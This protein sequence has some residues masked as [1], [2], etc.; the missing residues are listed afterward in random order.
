MTASPAP[1]EDRRPLRATPP[2]A[3]RIGTWLVVVLG[4]L[5]ATGPFA[6]DLYLPALPA[7]ARDFG[8]STGYIAHSVS[9]FFVGL[10]VGQFI[11]GPIS[12]RMGRR[13][14]LLFGLVLF[15]LA[16]FGLVLAPGANSLI[17]GRF[18][19]A[20]GACSGMVIGRAIVRDLLDTTESARMFSLLMLVVAV[21]PMLAPS[22]GALL[23]GWFG[24][25][26]I[27]LALTAFAV[28]ATVLSYFSLPE[29][30]APEFRHAARREH[31]FRSYGAALRNRQVLGFLLC[32][33]GNSG[34]IITYLSGA[35]GL[36][37]DHY[38]LTPQMFGALFTLNAVGL[39]VATQINRRMLKT[40]PALSIVRWF[41]TLSLAISFAFL[42]LSLLFELPVAFCVV[43]IFFSLGFYGF[44]STN[45]L[46]LALGAMPERAGAISALIGGG[47]FLAG[48]AISALVAPYTSDG[49]WAM[50]VALALG[51]TIS[52][53]ALFGIVG[54]AETPA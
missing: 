40:I 51:F 47:A 42:A 54:R 53:G 33:M 19:Q 4:L 23:L 6:I 38:R 2:A 41:T 15:I 11:Y 13:P 16:S 21:A 48:A 7:I 12:D 32:A 3:N 28:L 43:L 8:T 22:G 52:W 29:S 18:V 39:I 9:S 45:S 37:I 27:F 50:G 5:T 34:A 14:P 24:W 31:P 20:L 10:G 25:R 36:F 49:P 44:I 1:A 26:S 30:L 35:A 46:A 17:V